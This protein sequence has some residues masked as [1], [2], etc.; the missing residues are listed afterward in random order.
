MTDASGYHAGHYVLAGADG[1]LPRV[2]LIAAGPAAD[3]A[4]R[5]SGSRP[6][7]VRS[8]LL[9]NPAA[10]SARTDLCGGSPTGAA[11]WPCFGKPAWRWI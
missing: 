7:A 6:S 4:F 1:P 5:L 3:E 2:D 11:T 10:R 9:V 8:V